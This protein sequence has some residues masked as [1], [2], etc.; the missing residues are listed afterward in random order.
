MVV[1]RLLA[2]DKVGTRPQGL[3]NL[4]TTLS[5]SYGCDLLR[6][7]RTYYSQ[8]QLEWRA[9]KWPSKHKGIPADSG[10]ALSRLFS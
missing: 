10:W 7:L 9:A 1:T 6:V 4:A 2:Y 3:Y 8:E 5:F